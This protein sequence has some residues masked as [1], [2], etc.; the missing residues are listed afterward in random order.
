MEWRWGK[1]GVPRAETVVRVVRLETPGRG[2]EG[3]R[4]GGHEAEE[5]A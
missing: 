5:A 1:W 2:C 3:G 4:P